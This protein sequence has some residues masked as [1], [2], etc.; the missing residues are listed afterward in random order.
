M[1]E[2]DGLHYCDRCGELLTKKNNK[3]GY[4]ICDACDDWLEEYVAKEKRRK[5]RSDV[6]SEPPVEKGIRQT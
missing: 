5:G 6:H 2:K 3:K 4:E 1:I